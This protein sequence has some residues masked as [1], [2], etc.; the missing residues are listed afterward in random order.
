MQITKQVNNPAAQNKADTVV[1]TITTPS[2]TDPTVD[3]TFDVPVGHLKNL[4]TPAE[5]KAQVLKYAEAY[6]AGKQIE[7][8]NHLVEMGV[9]IDITMV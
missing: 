7:T 5:T 4:N 2:V 3:M 1:V 8:L 6:L 9:L